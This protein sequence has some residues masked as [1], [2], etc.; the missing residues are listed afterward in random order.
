MSE[1]VST[2]EKNSV[3]ASEAISSAEARK[4]WYKKRGRQRSAAQVKDLVTYR[5]V[6]GYW[7]LGLSTD[8]QI[9]Y[10]QHYIRKAGKYHAKAVQWRDDAA[11]KF[12]KRFGITE[13]IRAS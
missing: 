10:N 13:K 2:E 6:R 12:G 3:D 1:E 9:Y 5:I 11:Q 4:T 8:M 7:P